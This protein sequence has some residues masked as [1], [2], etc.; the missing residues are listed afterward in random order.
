MPKT[1]LIII[2]IFDFLTPLT[3]R[4]YNYMKTVFKMARLIFQRSILIS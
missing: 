3:V 2:K 1:T 4:M